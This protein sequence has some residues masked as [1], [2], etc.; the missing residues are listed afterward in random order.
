MPY[1]QTGNNAAVPALSNAGVQTYEPVKNTSFSAVGG[2]IATQNIIRTI[3]DYT[4]FAIAQQVRERHNQLSIFKLMLGMMGGA[5]GCAA[6]VTGHY[7]RDWLD[8]TVRV[9]T[10]STTTTAAGVAT[11]FTLH[12]DSVYAA[13]ATQG[14]TSHTASSI[15]INDIITHPD[16]TRVMVTNKVVAGA[17]HTITITPLDA[18]TV[19]VAATV[20]K[21]AAGSSYFVSDNA[22]SEGSGLPTTIIPR[23]FRYTNTFQIV[24][25]A[26]GGTG[27][28]MTNQLY[29]QYKGMADG[30]IMAILDK[31]MVT[32][33]EKRSSNALM[34]GSTI[35]NPLI[36]N[37]NPTQIGHDVPV[38]GTQGF[39]D[40]VS[41]HGHTDLYN[42]GAYTMADFDVV[43]SIYESERSAT[44]E[45]LTFDGFGVFQSTENLLQG[46]LA[47]DM[48][49][50]L[51]KR[52]A[53]K[54]GTPSEEFQPYLE[55]DFSFYVG[56][57]SVRKSG[58]NF[59]FRQMHEFNDATGAG[60]A[61]YNYQNRRYITPIGEARDTKTGDARSFMGY[62]YKQLGAYSRQAVVSTI[63]GAGVAGVNGY[64]PGLMAGNEFDMARTGMVAELAFHAAC[65]NLFVLQTP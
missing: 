2:A 18:T 22:F 42:A 55:S 35:T 48:A 39:V 21:F 26:F 56:F 37:N 36:F 16:G 19:L 8:N 59:Y 28:E 47:G 60:A 31:D 58:Y 33:F 23:L 34:F 52:M 40:F 6:P 57:R 10:P 64:Y 17:T 62:D 46:Q 20:P 27:S 4:P 61:G 51:M 43:A 13:G 45:L 38:I 54:M 14:G 63:A 65:A 5:K 30:S 29:V 50:M 9:G 44:R 3:Y 11:T 7:E 41:Q 15:R 53:E 12:A 1:V 24:K 25:E 32:R 49:P